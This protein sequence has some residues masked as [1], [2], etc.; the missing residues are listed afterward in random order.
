MSYGQGVN[1]TL[2]PFSKIT[3]AN[4]CLAPDPAAEWTCPF[5]GRLT[6]EEKDVFNPA[7]AVRDGKV[8]L[9]YRAE[10]CRGSHQGTS[11]IGLAESECG[12]KFVK[13]SSP[14]LHPDHDSLKDIEWD[15]GCEDPR[16]VERA[17]GGYLMTYTAWDGVTARL[18]TASSD[19]LVHWTK[20]GQAFEGP[21]ANLWSK[22][23]AIV[24]SLEGGRP[25]AAKLKDRFWM[26][27]GESSLFLASSEDLISWE[28]LCDESGS[29]MPVMD[30]RPGRF[31]S[32]LVEP[33]PPPLLT[34]HGILLLYNA[35]N[36]DCPGLAH[37]SY[38]PGQ[39]LF[40]PENPARLLD[41]TQEPFLRVEEADEVWGQVPNVVFIEGL[42]H[43]KG[44]WLLYYGTADSLIGVASCPAG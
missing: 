23:G 34:E 31:D 27:W 25:K 38:S 24:T 36:A 11:R 20:N 6:W 17:D 1:W 19:N 15:G 37:R 30:P 3:E 44:R 5:S 22:S 16:V 41:R 33:G 32:L 39:A 4:P 35:A 21:F 14:V 13:N 26:Y 28:I 10:D 29:P 9:L 8:F 7:A 12:L 42:V 40:D 2:G 43:H 18:C